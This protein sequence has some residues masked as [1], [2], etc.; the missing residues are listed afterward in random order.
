[1]GQ[2]FSFVPCAA[3]V[4]H[5]VELMLP[6]LRGAS[7]S[8]FFFFPSPVNL[9]SGLFLRWNPIHSCIY[10]CVLCKAADILSPAD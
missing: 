9:S 4:K 2:R 1:M 8:S 7:H 5:K 6:S 3:S 10:R